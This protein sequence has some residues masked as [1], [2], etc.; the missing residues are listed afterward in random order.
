MLFTANASAAVVVSAFNN[1]MAQSQFF[2][3]SAGTLS[4]GIMGSV[5]SVPAGYVAETIVSG[6]GGINAAMLGWGDALLGRSGKDRHAYKRDYTLRYLGYRSAAPLAVAC[7]DSTAA[8]T[9]A[10]TTTCVTAR[11]MQVTHAPQYNTES[12]KNYQQ[13]LLDVKTYADAAGIPYKCLPVL[14]ECVR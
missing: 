3:A 4:Y 2:D 14:C 13:T 1:F 8:R 11:G 12:G 6:G 9:T 10:P 5:T 7:S